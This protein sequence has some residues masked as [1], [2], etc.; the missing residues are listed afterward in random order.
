MTIDSFVIEEFL[1]E[2]YFV[3][4]TFTIWKTQFS[5]NLT[6]HFL[7][8]FTFFYSVLYTQYIQYVLYQII[9]LLDLVENKI[10]WTTLNITKSATLKENDTKEVFRIPIWNRYN[11]YS[12]LSIDV[13]GDYLYHSDNW[14]NRHVSKVNKSGGF[15]YNSVA[16]VSSS[17]SDIK[18]YH[19]IGKYT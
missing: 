3:S 12:T 18:I 5:V 4:V 2:Q 11:W 6:A 19:G 10:Y 9:C 8:L 14:Q 15:L 7:L 16:R 1:L 17:I 13:D